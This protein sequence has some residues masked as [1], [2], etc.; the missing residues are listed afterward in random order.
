MR[1]PKALLVA[2]VCIAAP[3]VAMAAKDKSTPVAA[4]TSPANW[5]PLSAYPAE[6]KRKGEQGRVVVKLA[7]DSTGTP[8]ACTVVSSSGSAVLDEAT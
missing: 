5:F 8:T 6:A 3:T 7:I 4:E 2:F 1:T